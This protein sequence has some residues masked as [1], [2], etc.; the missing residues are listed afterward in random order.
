[1]TKP[2]KGTDAGS[3][4]PVQLNR[5]MQTAGLEQRLSLLRQ[6]RSIPEQDSQNRDRRSLPPQELYPEQEM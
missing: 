4:D 1:M 6:V 2:A 5:E 3:E